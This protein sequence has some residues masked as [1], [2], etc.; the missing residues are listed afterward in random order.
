ML[1]PEAQRNLLCIFFGTIVSE[2]T[3]LVFLETIKLPQITELI[4]AYLY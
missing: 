3:A 1:W 4:V 2:F